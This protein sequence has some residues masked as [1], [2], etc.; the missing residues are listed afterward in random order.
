MNSVYNCNLD[1]YVCN[2]GA[3]FI[4]DS[5]IMQRALFVETIDFFQ[6]IA[7][8]QVLLSTWYFVGYRFYGSAFISW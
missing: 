6:Y 5:R 2:I 7:I 4:P 1:V 3:F 8:I